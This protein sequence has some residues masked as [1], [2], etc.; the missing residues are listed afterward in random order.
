MLARMVT[1]GKNSKR[2]PLTLSLFS[3]LSPYEPPST[4]TF[5]GL[6]NYLNILN[7]IRVSGQGIGKVRSGIRDA[8]PLQSATVPPP[9]H[10]H[11]QLGLI[12]R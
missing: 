11:V 5:F 9:V 10:L 4:H 7:I 12:K 1:I 2:F 8:L 6:L 3:S